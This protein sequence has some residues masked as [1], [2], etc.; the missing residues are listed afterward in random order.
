MYSANC[1]YS[2]C[3][4]ATEHLLPIVSN[5]IKTADSQRD[6]LT[7]TEVTKSLFKAQKALSKFEA[8]QQFPKD[9]VELESFWII[10]L[11]F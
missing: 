11:K 5:Y 6:A 1:F 4:Q 9:V 7:A 8:S 10:Y 2:V 3:F